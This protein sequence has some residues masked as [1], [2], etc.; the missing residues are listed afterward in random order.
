MTLI[1]LF[2]FYY[3]HFIIILVDV[4]FITIF[5]L[6]KSILFYHMS[7]VL[8]FIVS[9]FL[10]CGKTELVRNI[11]LHYS[12]KK[13]VVIENEVA[14]F[15][16]DGKVS[17]GGNV[18]VIEI[19]D[20]CISDVNLKNLKKTI[21][22]SLK[23][24]KPEVIV[25]EASGAASLDPILCTLKDFTQ[26]E[27]Y[28]ITVID[29]YRFSNAKKLSSHTLEHIAKASLII[30]NK[31][32]LISSNEKNK[33]IRNLSLLNSNIIDTVKS[34]IDLSNIIMEKMNINGIKKKKT[35]SYLFWK[36]KNNLGIKHSNDESHSNINAYVYEVYGR[37]NLKCLKS[38]FKKNNFPRAKGFIYLEDGKFYYFNVIDHTFN[39]ELAPK[40]KPI[41]QKLNRIV[42]IGRNVYHK[43]NGFRNKL[44]KCVKKS[45]INILQNLFWILKN[46]QTIPERVVY[47][48]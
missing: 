44:N 22:Y 48:E 10:G 6:S 26:L 42:L 35:P 21:S 23:N 36:I 33:Q 28:G 14:E 13:I 40:Q 4:S 43:R 18:K 5:F 45:F 3:S 27:I 34:K 47:L 19:N 15:G 16:V 41:S 12:S 37:V 25:I 31:C 39:I 7:K 1:L 11:L 9:G 38:F 8:T 32:D 24:F 30:L 20:G 29:A 46:Q 17:S 2:S